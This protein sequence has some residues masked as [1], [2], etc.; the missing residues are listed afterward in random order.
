M[1]TYKR[2]KELL[3]LW[4]VS[5][6]QSKGNTVFPTP[7]IKLISKKKSITW[8]HT[9]QWSSLQWLRQLQRGTGNG[10]LKRERVIKTKFTQRPCCPHLE[11]A[12]TEQGRK[13]FGACPLW[14][15]CSGRR[16][17]ASVANARLPF[18]I[19]YQEHIVK[20]H[21]WTPLYLEKVSSPTTNMVTS[22]PTHMQER[23][24]W[25]P[26]QSTQRGP[27]TMVRVPAHPISPIPHGQVAQKRVSGFLCP[28]SAFTSTWPTLLPGTPELISSR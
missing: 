18:S 12:R 19:F 21:K 10:A 14:G 25:P 16:A 11:P 6:Q 4:E 22:R 26:G 8:G 5:D 28:C 23:D 1:T 9:S 2:K 13:G 27:D 7:Y 20:D 24:G 17:Q 3:I 15:H